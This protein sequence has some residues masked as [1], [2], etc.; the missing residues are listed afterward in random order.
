MDCSQFRDSY[1]DYADGLLDEAA[2]VAACRHLAECPTC[3]RFDLALQR[4]L[5]TLRG[6]APL[7]AHEDFEDRLQARILRECAGAREE[8][9]PGLKHFVGVAGAM[10]VV[11]SAGVVG[12]ELTARESEEPVAEQTARA[13]PRRAS[14]GA[15]AHDTAF[16][17]D[18]FR[19]IPASHDT[20]LRV[21]PARVEITVDWMVP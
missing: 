13:L 21:S 11:V 20:V 6:L 8:P 3:R 10:A 4:G 14:R 16:G 1:S 2:E 12:W 18:P 7:R 5:G 17:R 15:S 19:V 9:F